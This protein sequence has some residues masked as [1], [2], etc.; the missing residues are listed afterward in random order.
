M[1]NVFISFFCFGIV[2]SA[3]GQTVQMVHDS[4]NIQALLDAMAKA[5]NIH[6]AKTYSAAFSEEADFTD[7]FGKNVFG[8][9]AI[10]TLYEKSFATRFK[11][12]SLNITDKK[13]RYITND[14]LAVDVWWEMKDVQAA[15][16]IEIPFSKG[17]ANL[18]ITRDGNRW[19]ILIMHNMNLPS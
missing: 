1:K 2:W 13:I 19:L 5:W 8:R 12:S 15:D 3:T 14:I 17:M 10:Q 6:D 9:K 11:N 7:V 16:G 18:L 4:Q